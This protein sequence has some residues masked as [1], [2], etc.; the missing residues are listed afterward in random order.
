MRLS[1]KSLDA[2]LRRSNAKLVS[3]TKRAARV[4]SPIAS[5]IRPAA[6]CVELYLTVP[7]SANR[8]WGFGRG[9]VFKT[10]AYKSWI[11]AASNELNRQ[12]P[13]SIAGPYKLAIQLRV[14]PRI[15]LDN[16]VK[17]VN[18]LMQSSGVVENDRHCRQVSLR[19]VTS[20][21]DGMYVRVERAGVE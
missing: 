10:D 14:G 1:Q 17:P 4:S 5:K 15:D 16:C 12:Y 3:T 13:G 6:N 9:R 7:P 19:W 8:M 21:F 2:L 20:G 11:E 18:D